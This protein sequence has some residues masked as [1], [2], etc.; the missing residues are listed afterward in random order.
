MH[1]SDPASSLRLAVRPRPGTFRGQVGG[2]RGPLA[3]GRRPLR[4]VPAFSLARAALA[5]F[6][7]PRT[8]SALVCAALP[9]PVAT[10]PATDL[11]S[12]YR[13]SGVPRLRVAPKASGSPGPSLRLCGG[14]SGHRA[15]LTVAERAEHIAEWVRLVEDRNKRGQVA[16]VSGKGGRGKES[17]ASRA[18]RELGIERTEIRRAAKIA[19]LTPAAKKAARDAG[20]DDNQSALLA[21][22]A[23]FLVSTPA[24]PA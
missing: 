9:R 8:F 10:S 12:P 4:A 19:A 16:Q 6:A 2:T 11:R 13:G 7:P 1:L 15:E 23:E 20:L 3:R 5:P 18:S 14:T 24:R 17:G 21:A 22:A